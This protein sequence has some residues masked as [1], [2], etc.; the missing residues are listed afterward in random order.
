MEIAGHGGQ[1]G[2][3]G[4]DEG[5]HGEEAQSNISKKLRVSLVH[6]LLYIIFIST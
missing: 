1:Q 3:E 6:I 4:Q 2:G 5:Q